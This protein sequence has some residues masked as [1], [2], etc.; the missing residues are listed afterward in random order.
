[1]RFSL[2][3]ERRY[4]GPRF[5]EVDRRENTELVGEI[6]LKFVPRAGGGRG[7]GG[8]G[9]G[10][11]GGTA[12]SGA[13]GSR[14]GSRGGVTFSGSNGNRG[15]SSYGQGGGSV[16]TIGGGAFAGRSIGGGSRGQVYGAG[17]YGHREYGPSNNDSRPGGP[18]QQALVRSTEWPPEGSGGNTTVNNATASY[19]IV[20]DADSVSAVMEAIV[21]QC[22]VVNATGTPFDDNN[23]TVHVEQAVQYYR[24]SSFMLALTSYNNSA[25]L[26]ANAP[27]H[28][29]T[30]PP[31]TSADTPLPPGTNTTFLNCLNETIGAAVPIMDSAP[32]ALR[33]T[34]GLNAVGM[35][36]LVIWLLKV[37]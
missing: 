29:N 37:F 15:A 33:A 18:M 24:A 27:A 35:L 14:G 13:G 32:D 34:A 25:S 17:Y 23:S 20:G 4:V 7:G 11:R 30:A 19:Y 1:M 26:P 12:G 10:G 21:A 16:T 36:W 9:G 3:S 2:P 22:S 5:E 6:K 8:G 28:N 31:P